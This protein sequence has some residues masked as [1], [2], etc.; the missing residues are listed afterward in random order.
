M[1]AGTGKTSK[2]MQ[3]AGPAAANFFLTGV[4]LNAG[5]HVATPEPTAMNAVSHR[6]HAFTNQGGA[7]GR[8]PVATT[9]KIYETVLGMSRDIGRQCKIQLVN[10]ESGGVHHT[11][12]SG[13]K[14][15]HTSSFWHWVHN[16]PLEF[17]VPANNLLIARVWINGSFHRVSLLYIGTRS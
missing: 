1:M 16:P 8:V 10:V 6:R 4:S 9:V 15:R 5:E 7:D 13:V 11:F 14:D 3:V 17:I 12:D 2:L